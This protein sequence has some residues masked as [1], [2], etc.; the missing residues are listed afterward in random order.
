MAANVLSPNGLVWAN[1]LFG[2]PTVQANAFKIKK[3]YATAI[4]LGDIVKT[5]TSASQGYV[6]IGAFND[7]T[8]LGVFG[9]CLPYY[10]TVTQQT[11]HGLNGSWPTSAN[12]SA[13]IDCV[14]YS[15]LNDVFRIQGSGIAYTT[16]MRG[17]N[18]NFVTGTNGA[19]NAAGIS[20]LTADMASVATTNTFP[21]RI[22]G[23]AGVS[24]G[25]QD[26]ANTNPV[27]LVT[28]NPGWLESMLALGI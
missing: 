3:G 2:A 28:F 1:N 19:P 24:G 12:A 7:S 15:N 21:L 26:P 22:V 14:V 8:G 20:T 6:V 4:G 27:L 16:S 9:G 25:P 13:D 18:I 17:N 5:G 23:V 10:D 11:M